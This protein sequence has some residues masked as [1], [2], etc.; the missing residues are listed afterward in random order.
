MN[1]YCVF[2][3]DKYIVGRF[4]KKKDAIDCMI[5]CWFDGMEN[6]KIKTMTGEEYIK[7]MEEWLKNDKI[8][9]G[10]NR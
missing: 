4:H 8:Q 2:Q 6:L 5:D 9:K 1:L 3:D 7:Y 10:T